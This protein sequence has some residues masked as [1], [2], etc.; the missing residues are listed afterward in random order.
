[1]AKETKFQDKA[2][3][4]NFMSQMKKFKDEGGTITAT[5]PTPA[6]SAAAKAAAAPAAPQ[7]PAQ[8]D[9]S[10]PVPPGQ[11]PPQQTQAPAEPTGEPKKF[12]FKGVVNKPNN[13]PLPGKVEDKKDPPAEPK[14]D[15]P[16]PKPAEPAE[17]AK[18][19]DEPK[20]A[21][22]EPSKAPEYSEEA[23]RKFFKEK[24]GKEVDSIES[25]LKEPEPASDP[26]ADLDEHTKGFFEFKKQ[27]GGDYD[28]YVELNKDWK[29][30]DPVAIAR[31]QAIEK[32]GG[33]LNS[34]NVD[35]YL[36]S[37]L[38]IDDLS[39]L[40]VNDKA[41]LNIYNSDYI[42]KKA[43]EKEQY[44]KENK[45]PATKPGQL[46][47]DM[48]Q[49]ESGAVISKEKYQELVN[50]NQ[51]WTKSVREAAEK[52]Q[53]TKYTITYDDNGVERQIE[54]A[55]DPNQEER[56]GMTE[57]AVDVIKS[58]EKMFSTEK[59]PDLAGVQE[60]MFWAN[61]KNREKG[62]KAMVEQ[63]LAKFVEEM[64]RFK[65]NPSYPQSKMP[66]TPQQ[67]STSEN[68]FIRKETRSGI[69]FPKELFR[70]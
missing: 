64:T 30:M 58:F 62:I 40:S 57:S 38:K 33:V 37:K 47:E 65:S 2:G 19:G 69:A 49:L 44:F 61:P 39:Q 3:G 9:P 54:V 48:V 28:K 10:N 29:S 16:K 34:S 17:P 1:M 41:D 68:P 56:H 46:P 43:A 11:Q 53:P 63:A 20:P 26:F 31:Q 42:A 25:L 15:E 14:G 36:E 66:N 27:T 50:K 5:P 7:P 8:G 60:A 55:Y 52:V 18:S 59:G 24:Y 67:P 35:E 6:D 51:Q 45:A 32:S 22:T 23:V 13:Q 70:R 4:T 21:K 12:E